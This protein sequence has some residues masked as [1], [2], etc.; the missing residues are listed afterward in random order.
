MARSMTETAAIRAMPTTGSVPIVLLPPRTLMSCGGVNGE[1][2]VE[3]I[4]A[5]A[6]TKASGAERRAMCCVRGQR[7]LV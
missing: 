3:G 7:T 5:S 2:C 1:Q 6:A 4:K